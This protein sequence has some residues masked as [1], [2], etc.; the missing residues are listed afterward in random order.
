[1][2]AFWRKAALLLPALSSY[3]TNVRF[4]GFAAVEQTVANPPDRAGSCRPN[5]AVP[6][7][8]SPSGKEP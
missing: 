3:Q 5:L 2:A 4:F 7:R 1:M 6:S 8:A